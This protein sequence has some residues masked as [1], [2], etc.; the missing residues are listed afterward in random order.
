[1]KR[2][3]ALVIATALVAA[4]SVARAHLMPEGQGST[5]LVGTKAYT[6]LSIPSKALAAFDDDGDGLLS[7]VE[8]GRHGQAIETMLRARVRLYSDTVLGRIAWQTLSIEHSD[9]P[10][11]PMSSLTLVRVTEWS[12]PPRQLR[13]VSDIGNQ[14]EF[15]AILGE[16][17]EIDTLSSRR[18]ETTFFAPRRT[19]GTADIVM[20]SILLVLIPGAILLKTGRKSGPVE[21]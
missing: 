14:V 2:T 6:L 20:A 17:T 13:V 11:V 19:F 12:Q 15:R 8:L 16:R 18:T 10:D 3:F 21:A 1:V 5:R 7:R 9:T 4:P